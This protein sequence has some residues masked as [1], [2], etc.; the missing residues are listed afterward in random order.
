VTSSTIMQVKFDINTSGLFL[1][2]EWSLIDAGL[3][4]ASTM[5]DL[6]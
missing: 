5:W 2:M 1:V 6:V 3:V 4:S